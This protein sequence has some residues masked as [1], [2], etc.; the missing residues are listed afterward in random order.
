MRAVGSRGARREEHLHEEESP[1]A[2]PT[3]IMNW[4]T[5]QKLKS[6][7][8][9]V[10]L[11]TV[12][13]LAARE[14]LK[15]ARLL[16]PLVEDPDLKVR[17]AVVQALGGSQDKLAVAAMVSALR[18]SDR[19]IRWRAAKA[20]QSIG[21]QPASDEQ[22]VWRAVAQCEFVKAA[23][24][25]AVA[26][27]SLIAELEDANSP[28]RREVANSLGRIG[29]ARAIKPLLAAVGDPDPNIRV[30]AVD[31]LNG[32]RD[33]VVVA[34]LIEALKDPNKYVRAVAA[35]A[36]GNAA[37]T[38]AVEPLVA[39]LTDDD[40]AV[41]KAAGEALARMRDKRAVEPMLGLL[42]DPDQDVREAA[43]HALG[44][45]RDL[46]AVGS[47][48]RALVDPQLSVRNLASGALCKIDSKWEGLEQARL[49][50]PR[51]KVAL[52]SSDY[53]VRQAASEVLTRLDK[54][55]VPRPHSV[56]TDTAIRVRLQVALG[57]LVRAL[58]DR[59]PIL[60]LA[61]A[62]ALGRAADSRHVPALLSAMADSDRS[63][64]RAA[65]IALENL[66]WTPADNS[67]RV[68]HREARQAKSLPRQT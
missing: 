45:I 21:W 56:G 29:D 61:S 20:L 39:V 55:H 22:S 59:D 23:D 51:L 64:R 8:S 67:E 46:S 4:W 54:S 36:L 18:D 37:D 14:G 50:I 32:F 17:R 7:L 13:Q 47:L 66:G 57:V 9:R 6:R 42:N 52:N 43:V 24:F 62:E 60:R 49:A 30:A 3:H 48:I 16:A 33:P 65:A 15:A 11:N 35:A 63:V 58:S 53:W 38:S 41:R 25:G 10:R 40:W 28:S 26:V 27:E 44:E 68:L 12:E 34:K 1:A 31:A 2:A 19:D 5:E